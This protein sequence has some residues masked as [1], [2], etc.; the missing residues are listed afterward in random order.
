MSPYIEF[1]KYKITKET[2]IWG[3]NVQ[4]LENSDEYSSE[5]SNSEA[6]HAQVKKI[7]KEIGQNEYSLSLAKYSVSNDY[8]LCTTN[9]V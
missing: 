5:Y 3:H 9:W 1:Y 2:N 6:K 4:N 8:S 7:A